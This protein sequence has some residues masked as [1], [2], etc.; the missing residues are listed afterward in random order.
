MLVVV[1]RAIPATCGGLP[2][3]TV[4]IVALSGFAFI[5]AINSLRLFA[6]RVT[7]PTRIGALVAS[8]ASGSKSFTVS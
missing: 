3:P 2:G 4:P 5:Q 8:S 6:G 1:W 7:L